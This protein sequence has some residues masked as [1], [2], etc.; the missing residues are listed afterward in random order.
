MSGMA[1][2]QVITREGGEVTLYDDRDFAPSCYSQTTYL[3]LKGECHYDYAV[4]SPSVEP[5]NKVMTLLAERGVPVLSEPDLGY[6]LAQCKIIGVTGTNGKTTVVS[7]TA[8]L[9][10]TAG[11]EAV[12]CGNIGVPFCQVASGLGSD[13]IAVV[14][15]SSYQLQQSTRFAADYAAITN[16]GVDH[17][18]RHGSM[19]AYIACKRKLVDG[20][21]M[22][23]VR[24]LDLPLPT[25]A[26]LP[27]Y[28][29]SVEGKRGVAY[30]A[31]GAIWIKAGEEI[32]VID[33]CD[34]PVKGQHNLRN[35]LCALSLASMAV[36][37]RPEFAMGLKT[38]RAEPMRCQQLTHTR[39]YVFNDSKA[40]NL[41]ATRSALST[42]RGTVALLLG[43]YDKGES[44]VEFFAT[45]SDEV[46]E[47]VLFGA[48]R[49]R[50]AREAKQAGAGGRVIVCEDLASAV[51]VA[52]QAGTDNVLFSPASSSF[53]AYSGYLERGR[54]FE[55][56]VGEICS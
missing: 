4:V 22:G 3:A 29:Y 56:L 13:G 34:L 38:Y 15:M 52:C 51:R 45:L 41:S 30:Y 47:V 31:D 12:A 49:E 16:I 19:E 43:G 48:S 2:A 20:A 24:D 1:A 26:D 7:M 14:E 9:L 39:P 6:L 21:R 53:D 5:T 10:Q 28:G 25:R 46:K 37:Y 33:E 36:G 11:I 18:E 50:L 27:C 54:D 35:A 42:M 40:T 8:H 32:K 17:I 55:R 23:V 44:F